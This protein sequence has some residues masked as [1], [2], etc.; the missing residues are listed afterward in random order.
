M[1]T[2]NEQILDH[3]LAFGSITPLYALN[4]FGCMRLAS[5]IN[6]L[7]KKGYPINSKM[8]TTQGGKRFAQYSLAE[9][10]KPL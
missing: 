1:K 2:Q 4:T 5:R 9:D 10:Y 7:S 8:I 3:L 6:D